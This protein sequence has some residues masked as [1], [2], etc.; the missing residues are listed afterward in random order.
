MSRRLGETTMPQTAERPREIVPMN[1][2]DTPN[3][4]YDVTA[5]PQHFL[6]IRDGGAIG[7][8]QARR[9]LRLVQHWAAAIAT[10]FQGS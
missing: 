9:E 6:M 5:A 2:V 4:I 1:G 8:E 3:P 7:R 10:L